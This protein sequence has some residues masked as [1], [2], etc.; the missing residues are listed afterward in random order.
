MGPVLPCENVRPGNDSHDGRVYVPNGILPPRLVYPPCF[1][2]TNPG[3]NQ[4]KYRM[5]SETEASQVKQQP[6]Q[7]MPPFKLINGDLVD[8]KEQPQHTPSKLSPGMSFDINSNPYYQSQAKGGILNS[9]IAID[10]KFFQ[11]HP[12]FVAAGPAA[13]SRQEVG[14]VQV[15]QS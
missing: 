3:N 7:Y 1:F 10:A 6:K 8:F 13:A 9:Q 14:V 5:V 15:G 4:D 2:R 11:T 12:Q